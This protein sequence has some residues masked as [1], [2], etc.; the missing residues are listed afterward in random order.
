MSRV[1]GW[2]SRENDPAGTFFSM[3]EPP[4]SPRARCGGSPGS[5]ALIYRF[6]PEW[7]GEVIAEDNGGRLPVYPDLR[8]PASDIPAQAR[9]LYRLNRQR[10]IADAYTNPRRSCPMAARST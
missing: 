1:V 6:D 2:A 7:N 3:T 10:L 4:A 5:T 9:E 8:W